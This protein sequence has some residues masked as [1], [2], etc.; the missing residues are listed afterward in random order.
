MGVQLEQAEHW[1]RSGGCRM[2]WQMAE[3]RGP[4]VEGSIFSALSRRDRQA[5]WS[6][7][8]RKSYRA[9]QTVIRKGEQAEQIFVVVSGR[10]KALT[11]GAG[12]KQ[13][14]LSIMGPGEVFGEV[15]VLDGQP[16]SATVTALER[17]ELLLIDKRALYRFIEST[18]RVA[19]RLLEVLARRLRQLTE[20]V[21]RVASLEV[22]ARLARALC[23]LAADHGRAIGSGAWRIELRL[24][25]QELGEL[26]GASRETVNKQLR[27]WI[28]EGLIEKQDGKLVL[29]DQTALRA[30]GGAG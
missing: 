21:G 23:R 13:A 20:R 6:L 2:T 15:A 5:L 28:A 18:P 24:S 27:A 14:T 19:V 10:L 3:P 30:R 8:V 17:C 11:H 1:R 12:G 22:P 9:R 16:R 25:Q 4:L 26:V 29:L 7:A